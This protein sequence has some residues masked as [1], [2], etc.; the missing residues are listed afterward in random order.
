MFFILKPL[1]IILFTQIWS[2]V[3]PNPV[4]MAQPASPTAQPT[5]VR[6]DLASTATDAN[7][8]SCLCTGDRSK[9]NRSK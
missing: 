8:R 6:V 9:T 5:T 3:H 1:L 4:S 2:L 7:V